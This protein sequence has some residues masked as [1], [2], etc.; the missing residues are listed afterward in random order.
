MN[1]QTRIIVFLILGMKTAELTRWYEGFTVRNI[2]F[3]IIG[4]VAMTLC[5]KNILKGNKS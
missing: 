5:W 2:I 3:A 1:R 4:L